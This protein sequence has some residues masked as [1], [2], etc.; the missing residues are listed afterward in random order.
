MSS[1][2]CPFL[3][4]VEGLRGRLIGNRMIL[5]FPLLSIGREYNEYRDSVTPLKAELAVT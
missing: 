5:E 4:R 3:S 1:F 2:D